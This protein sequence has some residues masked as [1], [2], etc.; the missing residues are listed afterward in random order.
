[1]TKIRLEGYSFQLEDCAAAVE[2]MLLAITSLDYASVWIDGWLRSEGR[3]DKIAEIISLPETKK[4]QIIL[5][6]GIP[7]EVVTSP[8][9][10]PFSERA[11]F[12]SYRK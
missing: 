12:N 3:A 5:P 1:M 10:K 4:V 9:K 11:W 7:S 8:K 6:V 2:N